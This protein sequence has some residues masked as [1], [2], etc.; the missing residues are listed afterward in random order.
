M[1]D[2]RFS[3]PVATAARLGNSAEDRHRFV[4]KRALVT[5]ES[6]VL[7]TVNGHECLLASL[8]LLIRICPHVTVALPADSADLLDEVRTTIDPLAFGAPVSYQLGT[9]DPAQFDAT[10]CVGTAARPEVPWT[11]INSNGWLA[12]V[13]SGPT[14][15]APDCRQGNPIGALAAASL[16]VT[17]VFKRL[18]GLK[19]DRGT[20]LDGFCFSLYSYS[21]SDTD[22][23]PP[24]PRVVP[25]NLLVVGA[26]AIGNGV[27]YLLAHLPVSGSVWIVDKQAFGDENLGTCILIG[28]DDI[29]AA[30]AGFM[31]ALLRPSLASK[32][33]SEELT[34]FTQ[35]LGSELPYPAV[36][37]GGVDNIEARHEIQNLW[38]DL[39]IDGAIG[40]FMCE[41][42]RHPWDE[43]V[44][45]LLCQFRQAAG[46]AAEHVASHATGL[47]PARTQE[48]ED[49]VSEAD[50]RAALSE[51]QAWL[52]DR[53]G[54]PICSVVQEAVAQQLSD[55][56]QREGF[57][58]SIPFVACLSAS[59][60]VGELVK[61]AAGW[62][63]PLDQ[64]FQFDVLRGPACG[65]ALGQV[66]RP[67]CMCVT[68]RGNIEKVR[69]RRATDARLRR[70][71]DN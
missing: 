19:Q 33:F 69:R 60:V 57:E 21:T 46:Q 68:R 45:C 52:R 41:V 20:L 6:G 26:G 55:E 37:L 28:P 30:K 61:A 25:L 50:V 49:I 4:D 10:L 12:R 59:M 39:A 51:K 70:A 62:V 42:S 32:G 44:A 66:R 40:D 8:R 34:S 47:S 38:P 65:F 11:V 5:G 3:R 48:A 23:G 22:P 58:P 53:I 1:D 2:L 27:V 7:A 24:L 35:R 54:R 36:V 14:S 31:E 16:G 29:G 15:L 18:V 13:S 67:D 17:E 64:R 56:R 9:A 63:S 43:D 71:A